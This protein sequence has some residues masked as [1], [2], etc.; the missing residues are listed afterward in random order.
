MRVTGD[1]KDGPAGGGARGFG[2]AT[3]L[4][5][6]IDSRLAMASVRPVSIPSR[7][8]CVLSTGASDGTSCKK[9]K[10]SAPSSRSFGSLAS[11][12]SAAWVDCR[13]PR[14]PKKRETADG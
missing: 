2:N 4:D 14:R 10:S 12:A 6:I 13:R 1:D 7:S 8:P 3:G 9:E 5:E 11:E